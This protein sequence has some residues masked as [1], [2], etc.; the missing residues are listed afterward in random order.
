MTQIEETLKAL[1]SVATVPVV[2]IDYA[3]RAVDIARALIDGGINAIEVT[4]RTPQAAKAIQNIAEADLDITLGAGS[5]TSENGITA[6]LQAGADFLVTPATPPTL[7]P[8]LKASGKLVLPG[9]STPSEALGL[10]LAGFDVLKIFPVSLLGG[11]DYISA[12]K[13][14]LAELRV[15]PSGGI[16]LQNVRDYLAL[17]NVVAVGVSWLAP[18]DLQESKD[19]RAV[20]RNCETLTASLKP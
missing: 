10:H 1:T 20:T 3:D 2:T 12:L 11:P 15:M 8:Y 18:P 13:A 14:P 7:I 9:V 6:A 5:V 19:W 16:T 17:P 4:L